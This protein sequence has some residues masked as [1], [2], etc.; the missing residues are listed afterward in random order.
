MARTQ[1]EITLETDLCRIRFS[2]RGAVVSSW[3]LKRYKDGNGKLL[4]LVNSL[5]AGKVAPPFSLTFR[6]Q[7][8]E[9]DLNQVLYAAKVSEDGLAVDFEYSSGRVV[10]RKSF[11]FKKDS[12]LWRLSDE[13]LQDGSPLPHYLVWRGGFGDQTVHSAHTL[14]HSLFYDAVQS[15]LVVNDTAA[16]KN[17]PVAA[18]GSYT[19]AGIED[20]YFAAVALPATGTYIE[21]QTWSDSIPV[22]KDGKEEALHAG[23]AVGGAGSNQLWMFVGPKDLDVMRAVSPKLEL[24]IDWGWFWFLA[25][26]L[27]LALHWLS[28]HHIHSY[29]WSIVLITVAINILLLP[30]KFTSLKSMKKMAQIQPQIAAINEKFKHLSLRDPKKAEQNQ[31]VMALYKK[32]GVNPMGGC[33]PIALQIPFF[34]AFYKVLSVVIELRGASWLWIS[35]LSQPE[36]LA[37]KV[38]PLTMIGTQFVLQ[39]MTPSTTADPAQQRI[40]LL[41][42]LMLGFMFYNVSSGLVLYWLTGNLVGIAQQWFFNKLAPPPAVAAKPAQKKKSGRN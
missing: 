30:L 27:F 14:Q 26:P 36:T 34:I 12:Y 38:L 13:V 16:G 24:M 19:F 10:S 5:A 18:G 21:I 9:V 32:H 35:D 1:E 20:T 15:K 29:G 3:E 37:I 28:E 22:V 39:K 8:P 42:P 31:E 33:M 17:G 40:M 7:K 41:M 25:K 11:R 6:D 2:N 4:D 23:S